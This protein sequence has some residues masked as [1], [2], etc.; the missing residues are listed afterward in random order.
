VV[1]QDSSALLASAEVKLDDSQVYALESNGRAC[2]RTLKVRQ[3]TTFTSFRGCGQKSQ[4]PIS[5]VMVALS[6]HHIALFIWFNSRNLLC[7]LLVSAIDP[8]T[9]PTR[10]CSCSCG[11]THD[12]F[13]WVGQET[14]LLVK[15]NLHRQDA[16]ATLSITACPDKVAEC[17][18]LLEGTPGEVC[19]T[20]CRMPYLRPFCGTPNV[21]Y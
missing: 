2:L 10:L 7:K 6:F 19:S 17:R 8:R 16:G 20:F 5:D 11:L 9:R 14:L 3:D 13:F 21:I 18:T 12:V 1:G 15:G 4:L